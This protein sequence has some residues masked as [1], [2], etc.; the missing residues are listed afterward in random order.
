MGEATE[1]Q[2]RG[3]GEGQGSQRCAGEATEAPAE[4]QVEAPVGHVE[5]KGE[6]LRLELQS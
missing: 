4:S 2:P 1:K 5:G 3:H 6:E